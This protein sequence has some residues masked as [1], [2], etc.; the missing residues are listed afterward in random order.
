VTCCALLG[1]S[2]IVPMHPPNV[3]QFVDQRT[4]SFCTSEYNHVTTSILGVAE[5]TVHV[6]RVKWPPAGLDCTRWTCR[7]EHAHPLQAWTFSDQVL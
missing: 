1:L 2:L 4:M 5:S 3:H 6:V 7:E